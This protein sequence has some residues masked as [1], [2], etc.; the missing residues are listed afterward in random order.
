MTSLFLR[1]HAC[2]RPCGRGKAGGGAATAC[3]AATTAGGGKKRLTVP[4]EY[5]RPERITARSEE[6]GGPHTVSCTLPI[7]T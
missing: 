4:R 1:L 3:C 2:S 5:F 6:R 7:D